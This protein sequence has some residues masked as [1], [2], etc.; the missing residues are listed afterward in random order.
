MNAHALFWD[1]YGNKEQSLFV[2]RFEKTQIGL[3]FWGFSD[4]WET[5]FQKNTVETFRRHF[6]Q[7]WPVFKTSMKNTMLVWGPQLDEL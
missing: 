7:I 3:S 1:R 2:K 4:Y 6:L 5:K